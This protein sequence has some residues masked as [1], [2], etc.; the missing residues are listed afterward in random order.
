MTGIPFSAGLFR[1]FYMLAETPFSATDNATMNGANS[2]VVDATEV[3]SSSLG[4]P[5]IESAA[6]TDV[7]SST[8]QRNDDGVPRVSLPQLRA[9]L[10]HGGMTPTEVSDACDFVA[11][12]EEKSRSLNQSQ[13][14]K[15]QRDTT[16]A[17]VIPKNA[18]SV[19]HEPVAVGETTGR[20]TDLPDAEEEDGDIDIGRAAAD[21]NG[22]EHAV[23]G[24]DNP[25]HQEGAPLTISFAAVSECEAVRDW[26]SKG[27]YTLPA[28]DITS[29]RRRDTFEVSS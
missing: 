9:I 10:S 26:V 8:D 4:N 29:G 24:Q 7:L 12:T 20:D 23:H 1:A 2:A 13:G 16:V 19:E 14:Q 22:E 15:L 11:E 28:F 25:L 6:S 3:R 18:P 17:N 21:G 5:R 27:A